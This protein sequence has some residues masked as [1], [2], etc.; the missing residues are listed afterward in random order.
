M[1]KQKIFAAAFVFLGTFVGILGA[2]RTGS[3]L[4]A[5]GAGGYGTLQ[6]LR[7]EDKR[8]IELVLPLFVAALLFVVALTLPHAK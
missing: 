5:L 3:V 4:I 6:Y 7:S 1:S 2:V 8:R